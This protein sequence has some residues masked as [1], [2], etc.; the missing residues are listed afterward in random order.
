MQPGGSQILTG[1]DVRKPGGQRLEE[2]SFLEAIG[3][4]LGAERKRPWLYRL[5]KPSCMQWSKHHLR[6]WVYEVFSWILAAKHT[7]KFS[8]MH[9][10]ALESYTEKA[11][12]N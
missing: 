8:E 11:W 3:L 6:F 10:H 5:E 4:K 12:G 7:A 2:Q 1:Q 9:Q